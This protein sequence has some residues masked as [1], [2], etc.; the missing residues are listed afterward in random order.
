MTGMVK[1]I[2]FVPFMLTCNAPPFEATLNQDG[3]WTITGDID[4]IP[5]LGLGA[6]FQCVVDNLRRVRPASNPHPDNSREMNEQEM[7]AVV[8]RSPILQPCY[9]PA[10]AVS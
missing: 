4:A 3:S 10:A 7:R 1:A 6:G 2:M 8:C 5:S 9:C